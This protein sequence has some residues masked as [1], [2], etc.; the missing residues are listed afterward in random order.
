M[1][2]I[3]ATN[4]KSRPYSDARS[5]A[6][7]ERAWW[8]GRQSTLLI[9]T[10]AILLLTASALSRSFYDGRLTA[11]MTHDDVNYFIEGIQRLAILRTR[12]FFA[13]ISDFFTG[14]L[15]APL[16]T[17]QAML[18]FLVFGVEDWA[19]Y[20]TNIVYVVVFLGFAAWLVRDCPAIVL[21]AVM[22][23]LIGMPIASHTITEFAPERVCG[24]FTAIGAILMVRLPLFDAPLA[25]RF[26]A[27]LCFGLAFLAHP[28]ASPFTMIALVA[29][30]GL[31]FLRDIGWPWE[32]KKL[33]IGTVKSLQN[34]GLSVW[35]PALY[36]V[37]RYHEYWIYF[38]DAITNPAWVYETREYHLDH[39][40]FYLVGNGGRF[41]FG[42]ELWAY[43][44]IVCLGIFAAWWH[45]DWQTLVRQVQ[46]ALLTFVFW[47]V[48]ALAPEKNHLF[49]LPFGFS[50]A[51][52]TVIALA[53]IYRAMPPPRGA[54]VVSILGF[55]LLVFYQPVGFHVPNLPYSVLEREFAWRAIDR[56]KADLVGNAVNPHGIKVYMTNIGAYAPN[57]LQYYLLKTNPTLDWTFKSLAYDSNAQHH[58]DFIRGSTRDYTSTQD[59]VIAGERDNGLTYQRQAAPAEDTVYA[60]MW[61]DPNFIALDRFRGPSGRNVTVFARRGSFAGWRPVYA[62]G[63]LINLQTFAARPIEADLEIEW[64][65]EVSGQQLTIIVNQQNVAEL[66]YSPEREISSLRQQIRLS[67]G[68][69]DIALE[70]DA[71][72]KLN[73]L[74]IVPYIAGKPPDQG[75]SVATATYGRNCKAPRGNATR[76]VAESCHGKSDCTYK[77]QLARLGDPAQGCEKNFTVS[78]FCPSESAMRYNKLPAESDGKVV[79]LSCAGISVASATYGGNCGAP[80]GNA[81]YDVAL[82]CNEKVDCKYTVD[83]SRLGDPAGGCDKDF[84]ISYF[85][86]AESAMRHNE[87][88]GKS[89][90][91]TLSLDC[92]SDIFPP[93]VG[94]SSPPVGSSPPQN[95][96]RNQSHQH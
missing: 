51:F 91:Q 78:Y 32:F 71:P 30:L 57:I 79:R 48:P 10:A 59:F 31:N 74:L 88:S 64:V 53:S 44:G 54:A 67:G 93:P 46:L 42:H 28:V 38:H 15:H 17:Y 62:A 21:A 19:P 72:V 49:G 25:S 56:I 16:L 69:N 77:I 68:T 55:S 20:L 36:V 37:P 41:M 94:S 33:K 24:L 50:V 14:F 70:S 87:L 9:L 27:G 29:T 58:I 47:L 1:I 12:G 13:L 23:C 4:L 95:G 35:L 81:T 73:H 26:R 6:L 75:I 60:A 3:V 18:A 7:G 22:A 92:S 85:C 43:A 80:Q 8:L 83:T 76:D 11:P 61:Q 86:R 66:T 89:D 84:A 96:Y 45:R 40:F 65:G 90:D 82:S 63:G 2:D 34:V 52:M 5:A 39:P